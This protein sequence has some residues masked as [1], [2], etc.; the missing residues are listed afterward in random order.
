MRTAR[1]FRFYLALPWSKLPCHHP[2]V[3]IPQHSAPRALLSTTPPPKLST[4]NLE[5]DVFVDPLEEYDYLVR[6]GKIN[7]DD[8]QR[9]AVERLSRLKHQLHNYSPLAEPLKPAWGFLGKIFSSSSGTT[10]GSSSS[11]SSSLASVRP[12]GMYIYGDVGAG[13]TMIMDLFFSKARPK[14]KRRVH[15]NEFMLDVHRRIHKWKQSNDKSRRS[16]DPIPPVAESIAQE[17][18]LLCFDEFQVCKLT[19][20]IYIY[21]CVC[22]CVC[23]S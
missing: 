9:A 11:E 16:F 18:A 12:R 15:F 19:V 17:A 4:L 10:S 5:K 22:V 3:P 6:K 1:A 7:K 20:Y 13:K 14:N 21:V 23:V 8:S 2:P